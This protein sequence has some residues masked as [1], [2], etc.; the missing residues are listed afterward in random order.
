VP[1]ES[2][3]V[4][5][6]PLAKQTVQKSWKMVV[7]A[8]GQD[9]L[10]QWRV[11]GTSGDRALIEFC[12]KTGRTHQIRAHAAAMGHPIIGDSVYGGGVSEKMQLLARHILL[13]TTPP[14]EATAPVPPHMRKNVEACL[15]TL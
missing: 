9:A 15:G 8:K 1:G 6:S 12:P 14:V 11:L 3:G 5:D 7:D 10:T 2:E 13:P 4:I